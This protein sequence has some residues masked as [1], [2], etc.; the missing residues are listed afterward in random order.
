MKALFSTK[1]LYPLLLAT[2]LH[3]LYLMTCSIISDVTCRLVVFI[4]GAFN[5][6]IATYAK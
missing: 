5:A 6:I 1:K 4:I 2:P 3:Y